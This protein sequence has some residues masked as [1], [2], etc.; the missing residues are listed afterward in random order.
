MVRAKVSN[1][2]ELSYRT[3][4]KRFQAGWPRELLA[5]ISAAPSRECARALFELSREAIDALPADARE[6]LL[7]EVQDVISELPE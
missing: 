2:P 6:L 4:C 1:M 7:E 5:E 3:S